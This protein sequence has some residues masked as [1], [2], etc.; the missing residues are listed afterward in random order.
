[1]YMT[2]FIWLNSSVMITLMLT[3]ALREGA[4]C[5]NCAILFLSYRPT[6]EFIR[7]FRR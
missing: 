2:A 1:M 3:V 6:G 4:H 5:V 7:E